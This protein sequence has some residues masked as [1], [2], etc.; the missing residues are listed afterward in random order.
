MEISEINVTYNGENNHEASASREIDGTDYSVTC[1]G[2]SSC[3]EPF[4]EPS[5]P[6]EQYVDDE[7]SEEWQAFEELRQAA[8]KE[9]KKNWNY[10]GSNWS[11]PVD[12]PDVE[13]VDEPD[14][15]HVV[16]ISRTEF[17][18]GRVIGYATSVEDAEAWIEHANQG[19]DCVCGCYEISDEIE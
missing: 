2:L 9:V 17:H 12:E 10:N 16:K 8:I 11:E 15:N 6:F 4:C 14:E 18:G 5:N 7:A 3:G 13:L 1:N 19:T